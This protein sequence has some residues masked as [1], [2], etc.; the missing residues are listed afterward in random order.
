MNSSQVWHK[1]K[2]N[3]TVNQAGNQLNKKHWKSIEEY[4]NSHTEAEIKPFC[5]NR[6]FASEPKQLVPRLIHLGKL[7]HHRWLGLKWQHL[8]KSSTPIFTKDVETYTDQHSC[9]QFA[10]NNLQRMMQ[11]K[12]LSA[13][14]T[15]GTISLADG[16]FWSIPP[17]YLLIF[18]PAFFLPIY[19]LAFPSN[20][21]VSEI[22]ML[23][24]VTQPQVNHSD[25]HTEELNRTK[26]KSDMRQLCA[27][28]TH[29]S[30]SGVVFICTVLSFMKVDTWT[31]DYFRHI[32]A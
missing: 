9:K 30:I 16:V 13:L 25:R 3:K 24:G 26:S 5:L 2:N 21:S 31:I 1:Q 28:F 23:T 6:N 19:S 14:S 29:S 27:R 20:S 7:R 32:Q 10:I 8:R 11:L 18:S 4:W 15:N 17:F 22:A 12:T